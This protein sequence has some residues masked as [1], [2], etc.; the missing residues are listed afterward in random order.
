MTETES[1]TTLM[2]FVRSGVSFLWRWDE[3]LCPSQRKHD[4]CSICMSVDKDG[5][6]R[7]VVFVSEKENGVSLSCSFKLT[8]HMSSD[9][10]DFMEPIRPK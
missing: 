7:A 5:N 4:N 3:F 6:S 9:V 10:M 8:D 1:N 2:R